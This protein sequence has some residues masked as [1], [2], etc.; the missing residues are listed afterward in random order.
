MDVSLGLNLVIVWEAVNFV[1]EHL[2]V[3]FW[4]DSVGSRHS[5]VKPA[6]SFHVVILRGKKV[7]D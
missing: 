5:E 1:D 4:I 6:Q 3:D 2:K 7:T